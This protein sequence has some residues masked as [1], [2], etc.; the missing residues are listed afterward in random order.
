MYRPFITE[1]KPR[2][3]RKSRFR[4]L[5]VS[6]MQSWKWQRA[7]ALYLNDHAKQNM[8]KPCTTEL[9]RG[10]LTAC[11]SALVIIVETQESW[12]LSNEKIVAVGKVFPLT[13]DIFLEAGFDA[14][15]IGVSRIAKHARM[16]KAIV[17]SGIT[18]DSEHY[19]ALCAAIS[20]QLNR[21]DIPIYCETDITLFQH[22]LSKRHG[23]K[24]IVSRDGGNNHPEIDETRIH[25]R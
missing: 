12:L 20:S 5:G 23:A 4:Q 21:N 3:G 6:E 13:S 17:V 7:A 14:H 8:G 22:I 16:A 15:Q 1:I 2:E 19:F 11:Q 9:V 25:R 10:W 24:I 18:S